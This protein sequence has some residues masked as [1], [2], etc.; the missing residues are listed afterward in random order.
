VTRILKKKAWLKNMEWKSLDQEGM[1]R[2]IFSV[3]NTTLIS[4]LKTRGKHRSLIYKRKYPSTYRKQ[5]L[6]NLKALT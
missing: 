4:I 5:Q 3:I 6:K 2:K 1:K